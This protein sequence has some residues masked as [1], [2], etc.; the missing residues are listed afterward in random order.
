M[1]DKIYNMFVNP[2]FSR[3]QFVFD[4]KAFHADLELA[5]RV[6]QMQT[7]GFDDDELRDYQEVMCAFYGEEDLGYLYSMTGK[8]L[9][10]ILGKFSCKE[11]GS[12]SLADIAYTMT[13]RNPAVKVV[14]AGEIYCVMCPDDY[15]RPI[16]PY[17]DE[18][19]EC[20]VISHPVAQ[21]KVHKEFSEVLNAFMTGK[22]ARFSAEFIY[23]M[24]GLDY[25]EESKNLNKI[26]FIVYSEDL[27]DGSIRYNMTL[28]DQEMIATQERIKKILAGKPVAQPYSDGEDVWATQRRTYREQ[29]YD[30]ME[31]LV[32]D[33]LC[34]PE[35]ISIKSQDDTDLIGGLIET[36]HSLEQSV[37]S[38]RFGL[39][40]GICRSLQET[41]A[42]LG[43]LEVATVR[44]IEANAMRKLRHPNR[45]RL[46]KGLL[47]VA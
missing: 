24:F 18:F 6:D 32:T 15:M 40:D 31:I 5:R 44:F 13:M 3:D 17:E 9:G 20:T 37:L 14:E 36:L 7:M 29:G 47:D 39:T 34:L 16:I 38:L 10:K 30:P 11:D 21:F 8:K 4:E 27:E 25:N 42:E 19:E 45:S 41:A 1:K 22:Q 2:K 33:V 23:Y 35:V 46:I 43:I 12:V 28:Y 26:E